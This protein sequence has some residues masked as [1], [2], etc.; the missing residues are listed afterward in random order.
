MFGNNKGS[1]LIITLIIFSIVNTICMMC[2][3]LIG[4]SVKTSSLELKNLVLKERA[5]SC[6]EFV[7]LNMKDEVNNIIDK[8]NNWSE[9]V[10]YI[11]NDNFKSFINKSKDISYSDLDNIEIELLNKTP[12]GSVDNLEFAM[13]VVAI[14]DVYK[15]QISVNISIKN[16]WE[17]TSID[18]YIVE[19]KYNLIMEEEFGELNI[20]SDIVDTNITEDESKQLDENIQIKDNLKNQNLINIYNYEEL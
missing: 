1:I 3:S 9:F 4:S 6:I 18:N 13:K 16:P 5:L 14:D 19:D 8:T 7:S 2:I 12:F 17:D 15:K 10:N 11:R 20:D